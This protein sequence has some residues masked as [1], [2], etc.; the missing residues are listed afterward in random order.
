MQLERLPFQTE[1]VFPH[2]EGYVDQTNKGWN[3][4]RRADHA[5]ECLTRV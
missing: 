4:N 5:D 2:P 3:L 1:V